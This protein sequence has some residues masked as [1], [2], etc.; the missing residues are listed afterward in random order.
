MTIEHGIPLPPKGHGEGKPITEMGREIRQ[1]Q[2][3]DSLLY[4]TEK[5]VCSA[6]SLARREG[7]KVAQRK[8]SSGWRM[9]RIG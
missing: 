1:L 6:R 4:E 7:F 3:G 5:Q 8:T 9:W 2:V